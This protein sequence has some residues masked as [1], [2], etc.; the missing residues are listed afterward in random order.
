M[1]EELKN[2]MAIG[3]NEMALAKLFGHFDHQPQPETQS[4]A[5]AKSLH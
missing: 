3:S 5:D 1:A 2:P 4:F